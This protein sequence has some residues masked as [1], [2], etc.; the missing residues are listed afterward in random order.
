MKTFQFNHND[1]VSVTLTKE[2]AEF[3]SLKRKEFYDAYP[4]IKTRSKE[5]FC[6][7]E[8]YKTQFWVLMSDFGEVL[9]LGMQ[10]PFEL[11]KITVESS[12]E[13]QKTNMEDF[14]T[15]GKT[16][17]EIRANKAI[18]QSEILKLIRKFEED[19]EVHVQ[20]VHLTDAH[21]LSNPLPETVEV[22]ADFM[23]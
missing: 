20:Y 10:S 5:V 23:V 7:G 8:I 14:K 17:Q 15:K 18:L 2:G 3:L 11:G 6:E 22:R 13:S 16:I 1:Y 12:L 21:H 4:Q 19:N 9:Q